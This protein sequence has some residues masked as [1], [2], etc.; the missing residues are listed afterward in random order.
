MQTTSVEQLPIVPNYIKHPPFPYYDVQKS[1][2]KLPKVHTVKS[3][4]TSTSHC[5][6]TQTFSPHSVSSS[7]SL[8]TEMKTLSLKPEHNSV[9]SSNGIGDKLS[10][11][12]VKVRVC[13]SGECD[14]VE[15]EVKPV[16][17]L[18]LLAACCE[19]LELASSDVAKIRK[20]PNVLIRKDKDIQRMR[21]GQELEVVL[22]S[23]Q[24]K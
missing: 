1:L 4:N 18:A 21:D 9:S 17:Y 11:V 24:D 20:L 23:D 22:K 12:L 13:G 5:F 15:V 10:S 3:T 16:T 7:D 6:Q 2:E 8:S 19:E 14:F